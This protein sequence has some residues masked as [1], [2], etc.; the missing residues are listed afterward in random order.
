[1]QSFVF[2][3][4]RFQFGGVESVFLNLATNLPNKV[5]YLI[6]VNNDI[7]VE[8]EQK[9]PPNVTFLDRGETHLSL[10]NIAIQSLRVKRK[11]QNLQVTP[12]FFINFSDNLSSLLLMTLLS[13]QAKRV[14]WCH[15]NPDWLKNSRSFLLYKLL[16]QTCSTIVC[17]CEQQSINLGKLIPNLKEKIIIIPN[18]LN[19]LEIEK[20]LALPNVSEEYNYILMVA[21][22][23]ERSKDFPTLINAYANLPITLKAKHKLVL[24]GDGEDLPK[25]RDLVISKDLSDYV[26]FVGNSNNPYQWM[27]NCELFVLS[28]KSEGSP[29]VIFEAMYCDSPIIASDCQVGPSDLLQGGKYGR[30]FDV[31]NATQLN[32]H[33][34]D[35]LNNEKHRNQLKVLSKQRALQIQNVANTSLQRFFG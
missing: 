23:D 16:L 32:Q 19:L 33:M 6:T 8:L 14:S 9:L 29:M 30:L 15:C 1:M 3:L 20:K 34:I 13:P 27:K 12:I 21:R 26:V 11:L 7:N 24:V 31:G 22:F 35:L 4:H 18:Q 2:V 5:F 25:M 17:I 10:K 28:S